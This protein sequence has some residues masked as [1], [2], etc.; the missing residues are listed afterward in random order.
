[1]N[2]LDLQPA[3]QSDVVQNA[4]HVCYCHAKIN[5]TSLL[6]IYILFRRGP[7]GADMFWGCLNIMMMQC[8]IHPAAPLF[9]TPLPFIPGWSWQ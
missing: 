8:I 7:L 9:P 4:E 6:V 3:L 5:K 1:M 2:R